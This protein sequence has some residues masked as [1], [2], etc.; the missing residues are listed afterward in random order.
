MRGTP[1]KTTFK[2]T[3]VS[4][5]NP[6][7]KE[8]NFKAAIIQIGINDIIYESGSWKINSL[9]QNI[10]EIGKKCKSY[11]FIYAFVSSITFNPRKPHKLL[12]EVNG[13]TKNGHLEKNYCHIKDGNIDKNNLFKDGLH[14]QNSGEKISLIFYCKFTNVQHCLE[15]QTWR[16]I[17]G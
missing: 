11:G 7:L 2:K 12:K 9:L 4:S 15:T 14:L 10:N 3:S 13:M 5:V 1:E 6:T 17:D 16:K 8:Q